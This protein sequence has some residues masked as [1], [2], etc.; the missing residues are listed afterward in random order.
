VLHDSINDTFALIREIR[1]WFDGPP[2][3]SDAIATGEALLAARV[4]GVDFGYTGSP[5]IA[6]D[7]AN[8]QTDYRDM[9]VQDIV[10]S[11]LFTG[12]WGNYLRGSV[13]TAGLDPDNLPQADPSAMNFASGST[14]PKG[15]IT[16]WGSGQ[17]I[18][19]V[20][21]VGPARAI[22]DRMAQE[23]A[24]AGTRKAAEFRG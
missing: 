22:V 20:K 11:S 2:A 1:D 18:G 5:F 12:V 16:I 4:L 8:A 19:A 15:W 10:N 9:I 17:G 24:A 14:K 23:Y 7:E 13:E 21:P 3:L 6:T